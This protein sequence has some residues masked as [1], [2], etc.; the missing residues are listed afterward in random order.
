MHS[1]YITPTVVRSGSLVRDTKASKQILP[2]ETN[3]VTRNQSGGE[4]FYL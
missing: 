2:V 4:G 1:T 3:D